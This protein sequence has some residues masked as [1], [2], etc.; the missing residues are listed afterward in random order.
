LSAF[1][2]SQ[3]ADYGRLKHEYPP[4]RDVFKWQGYQKMVET[5][6]VLCLKLISQF[7]WTMKV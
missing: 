5:E 3:E 4:H 1:L 6:D 2:Q 7:I